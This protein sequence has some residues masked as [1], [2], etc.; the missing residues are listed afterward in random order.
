[1]CE[2]SVGGRPGAD[3]ADLGVSASDDTRTE[4]DAASR[5]SGLID[6]CAQKVDAVAHR[7]GRSWAPDRVLLTDGVERSPRSVLCTVTDTLRIGVTEGVSPDD[8]RLLATYSR[9][10]ERH[11]RRLSDRRARAADVGHA[12]ADLAGRHNGVWGGCWCT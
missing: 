1:M 6:R 9:L 10:R 7:G 5:P 4:V 3:G 8:G 12:F 2:R 11:R